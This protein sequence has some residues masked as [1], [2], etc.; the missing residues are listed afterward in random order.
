MEVE[1]RALLKEGDATRLRS[2]LAALGVAS[3]KTVAIDDRYYCP[4]SV[5]SFAEVEM[6]DVGSYSLRLRTSTVNGVVT[7]DI[8]TKVIT[9][10]GDHH[11]WDEHEAIINSVD[12][13]EKILYSMGFKTFFTL[14]KVRDVFTVDDITL[15]IEDIKDYG[16]IVEAEIITDSGDSE[17]AKERI[18]AL[19]TK[20]GIPLETVVPKSVTNLIMR[21]KARF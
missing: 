11:A 21:E 3:S 14:S 8:N 15:Q 9:A 18:R 6:D 5:T 19:F 12:E 7:H 20:L 17:A 10:H 16:T 2:Q 1:L 13:M 4:S